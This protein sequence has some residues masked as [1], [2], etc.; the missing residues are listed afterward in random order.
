MGESTACRQQKVH[1]KKPNM[2]TSP[3]E[4]VDRLSQSRIFQDY[5]RAFNEAT[6]LP[7]SITPTQNWGLP[8]HEKANENPFCNIMAKTSKA[9]AACLEV[10]QKLASEGREAPVTTTC[11]AGLCD[12][13]VPLRVGDE[14]LG[15]LQTGQVAM[16]APSD[17]QFNRMSRQLIKW[18]VDVDLKELREAY[19]NSRVMSP[20][21]YQA[22]V[23]LI[24]TFA[25]HLALVGNRILIHEENDENPV[26]RRARRIVEDHHSENLSL[27]KVAGM[28][29]TSTYYFCKLFKKATGMTFT[30]YLG[31]SRVE[32]AKELLTNPNLR[33]SEIAF[34]V[35]FESLS[36]F[37]RT[38][39]QIAGCSPTQYR[40]HEN[41]ENE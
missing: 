14:L 3:R 40:H 26:V 39:R 5:E 15:F 12:T 30:E 28:V 22:F 18:G 23:R 7:L 24:E 16:E 13:V 21:Q 10:Q 35:G 17:E 38:F 29:N 19:F 25:E 33:V 4:F 20:E 9:C 8:H 37:N 6:G 34:E 32:R 27:E 31:R 41:R 1:N 11:F 2:K 36:Q